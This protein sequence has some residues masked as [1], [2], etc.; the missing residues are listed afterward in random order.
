MPTR[1]QRRRREKTFRHD[2]DF[3]VLDEEGREVE[4]DPAE[5]RKAK[6][7]ERPKR[8]HAAAPPRAAGAR[9][10]RRRGAASA[11]ARRSS[12]R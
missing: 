10:S 7:K 1:K 9:S 12:C 8:Q 11:S 2:Y 3:V 5:L 6:E 4:V